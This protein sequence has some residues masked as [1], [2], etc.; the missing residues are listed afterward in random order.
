MVRTF[1]DKERFLRRKKYA[2]MNITPTILP[3]YF[4]K[5]YPSFFHTHLTRDSE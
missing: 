4:R 3:F 2:E 1:P 5:N